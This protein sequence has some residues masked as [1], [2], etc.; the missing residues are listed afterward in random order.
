[1]GVVLGKR[2]PLLYDGMSTVNPAPWSLGTLRVMGGFADVNADANVPWGETGMLVRES[3]KARSS[4]TFALSSP[5]DFSISRCSFGFKSLALLVTSGST[6]PTV[7]S[8]EE[9]NGERS[10]RSSKSDIV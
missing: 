2:K 10:A 8:S 9:P 1:V 3:F 7:D 5:N 6:S 4:S